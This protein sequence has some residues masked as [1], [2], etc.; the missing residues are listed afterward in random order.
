MTMTMTMMTTTTII[1]EKMSQWL[2]EE[3]D[4]NDDYD[5][6][7]D[8]DNDED[9]DDDE[10]VIVTRKAVVAVAKTT[11]IAAA[12]PRKQHASKVSVELAFLDQYASALHGDALLSALESGATVVF[13]LAGA[14][15]SATVPKQYPK[16]VVKVHASAADVQSTID[17]AVAQRSK[18]RPVTLSSLF[19]EVL[20]VHAAVAVPTSSVS[21]NGTSVAARDDDND[22]EA[23]EMPAFDFFEAKRTRPDLSLAQ[24]I[25]VVVNTLLDAKERKL[26]SWL[27]NRELAR[28]AIAT[29]SGG[30]RRAPKKT[31]DP[32]AGGFDER[33]SLM[34][35]E[36]LG[37]RHAVAALYA[38]FEDTGSPIAQNANRVVDGLWIGPLHAGQNERFLERERIGAIVSVGDFTPMFPHKIAYCE[39]I[40]RDRANESIRPVI[41]KCVAFIA[42]KRAA[43]VNVLVHCLG[44]RS[45][46]ATVVAGYLMLERNM[47]MA[48][49]LAT[50]VAV[51]PIASPN[52][53]FLRA[54]RDL[55]CCT[56]QSIGGAEPYS[57]LPSGGAAP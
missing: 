40:A 12:K 41:E 15:L 53:G 34:L 20:R 4:N 6:D 16:S 29:A 52:A 36:L 49:A 54:L 13:E 26:E 38:S 9:D 42:E 50:V 22:D 43:G 25:H 37:E 31:K 8:D 46:S 5:D 18:H 56:V 7:D 33:F 27:A 57:D 14:T 28:H 1:I 35:M 23:E 48:R 10:P 21:S 11:I 44:G 17:R 2:H 19:A 39:A 47:T 24:S 30:G 55:K 45:R 32:R 3:F 51:R